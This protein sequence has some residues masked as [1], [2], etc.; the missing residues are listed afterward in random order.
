MQLSTGEDDIV[1]K[2]QVVEEQIV[3]M[4]NSG[5]INNDFEEGW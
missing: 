2:Q 3:D 4:V 1:T 5:E